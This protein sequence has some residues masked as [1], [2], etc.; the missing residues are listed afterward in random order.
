MRTSRAIALLA[1]VSA[2]LIVGTASHA[3][4][5]AL[6][7]GDTDPTTEGFTLGGYGPIEHN[8]AV[9]SDT[10]FGGAP[11][12]KIADLAGG[13]SASA[14]YYNT[15]SAADLAEAKSQG[16]KLTAKVRVD[17]AGYN[18]GGNVTTH[19][20]ATEFGGSAADF[21]G[22]WMIRFGSD[23]AGSNTLVN[24]MGK[25]A[26]YTIPGMGYHQYDLIDASGA[27]SATLYVDGVQIATGITKSDTHPGARCYFGDGHGGP[28]GNANYQYV[29]LETGSNL[30]P[31]LLSPQVLY[32]FEGDSGTSFTDKLTHDAADPATNVV[33]S[34]P[35]TVDTDAADAAFGTASCQFPMNPST[36]TT[37]DI[38]NSQNLGSQLTLA[39][40]LQELGHDWTRVFSAYD[41]GSAPPDELWWGYEPGVRT[42]IGIQGTRFDRVP[43]ADTDDGQYHHLAMT[44]D[45]G[46]VR[47]YFDGKQLGPEGTSAATG[48]INLK[49]NLR[50]GEDYPGTGLTSEAVEGHA[51]DIL[52]LNRAMSPGQIKSLSQIGGTATFLGVHYDAEGDSGSATDKRTLDGAQDGSFTPGVSI[53]N[54]PANARFGDSSIAFD[55]ASGS[56]PRVQ[57][58][59]LVDLGEQFTLSTFARY[60]GS[61]SNQVRLFSNFDG[62]GA[63]VNGEVVLDYNPIGNSVKGIRATVGNFGTAAKPTIAVNLNDGEYHHLAMTYDQG[64][65][66]AFVDGIYVAKGTASQ[67]GAISLIRDLRLGEDSSAGAGSSEQFLGNMDDVLIL[68]HRALTKAEMMTLANKGVD[69]F[70]ANPARLEAGSLYN[71]EN[72]QATGVP[73]DKLT[74]DGVQ[75]GIIHNNVS[76][77]TTP[78]NAAFGTTSFSFAAASGGKSNTIEL[79]DSEQLG[80]EFTLAAMV[81]IERNRVARLFSSYDGGSIAPG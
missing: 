8:E 66:Y 30:E 36:R 17:G 3:G 59:D 7:Y 74:T 35:P 25:S 6:H 41:G 64:D 42:A 29:A 27:G 16:W 44:Y 4:V 2:L 72:D 11:A 37:F 12:W 57:V 79:A 32:T 63:A 39:V 46:K 81:N 40:Q 77:D 54:T 9:P 68:P 80:D 24:I 15:L 58:G 21:N 71:G 61:S 55:T 20:M 56:A 67:T 69:G 5:M 1:V 73:V 70:V 49:Y 60:D 38:P 26:T 52:V 33:G 45:H 10:G 47:I 78:A 48:A 50:F 23:D 19:A 31:V 28:T 51:D 43:P 75:S 22:R 34:P 76:I 14:Y 13:A 18:T 62:S 53:D 65:I